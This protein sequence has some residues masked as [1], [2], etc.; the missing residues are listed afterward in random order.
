MK[1]KEIKLEHIFYE[2]WMYLA[3]FHG[4]MQQVQL[5]SDIKLLIHNTLWE[6]HLIHLRAMLYFF[7]RKDQDKDTRNIYVDDIV[8]DASRYYFPGSNVYIKNDISQTLAH[9]S[10]KRAEVN[11]HNLSKDVFDK[12]K[13]MEPVI[14]HFIQDIDSNIKEELRADLNQN[15]GLVSKIKRELGETL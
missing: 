11:K 4:M 15:Q 12:Y 6:S 9:L 14:H 3:T 5:D 2:M 8:K 13:E 10:Y 7:E 1:H